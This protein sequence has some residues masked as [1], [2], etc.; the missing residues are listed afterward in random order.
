M[1]LEKL[2]SIVMLAIIPVL[3]VNK[4]IN[5]DAAE[6][7]TK[8]YKL[9][10]FLIPILHAV[11]K[12]LRLLFFILFIP[13]QASSLY[14]Y[15]HF[16]YDFEMVLFI[17]DIIF[18]VVIGIPLMYYLVM[19][20]FREVFVNERGFIKTVLVLTIVEFIF[21][22]DAIVGIIRISTEGFY[23]AIIYATYNLIFAFFAWSI[24]LY[25]R[26]HVRKNK[27]NSIKNNS[28]KNNGIKL[29]KVFVIGIV[30]SAIGIIGVLGFAIGNKVADDNY[31]ETVLNFENVMQHLLVENDSEI[32]KAEQLVSITEVGLYIS[33]GVLSAGIIILV[34]GVIISSNKSKS[35]V[36]LSET[37]GETVGKEQSPDIFCSYCG[38]QVLSSAKFCRHCGNKIE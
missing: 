11:Y 24:L 30:L 23:Y 28:I 20:P 25:I 33:I 31:E 17:S 36:L 26:K 2:L 21:I 38:K 4:S 6:V 34:V 1:I 14:L 9:L 10:S 13:R 3:V 16:F 32:D 12:V 19:K 27:N 18:T 29:N 15:D 22:I 37:S 35:N 7:K 8:T 5:S